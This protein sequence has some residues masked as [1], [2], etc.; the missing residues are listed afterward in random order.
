MEGEVPGPEHKDHSV[1]LG[2][3][4]GGVKQSDGTLV[5][6]PKVRVSELLNGLRI[7]SRFPV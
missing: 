7:L 4:V 6:N 2:V 5:T 3:E 1:R